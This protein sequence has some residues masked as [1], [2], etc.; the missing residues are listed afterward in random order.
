MLN[1]FQSALGWADRLGQMNIFEGIMR[2]IPHYKYVFL[3]NTGEISWFTGATPHF[4]KNKV[5]LTQSVSFTQPYIYTVV[6]LWLA[7]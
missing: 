6:F 7:E 1:S 3:Q 4:S 5:H 2:N